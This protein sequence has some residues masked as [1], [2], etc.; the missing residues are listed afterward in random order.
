MNISPRATGFKITNDKSTKEVES[1][2]LASKMGSSKSPTI[3][4][5]QLKLDGPGK[6]FLKK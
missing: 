3:N 2:K 5:K 6:T 4:T 1:I